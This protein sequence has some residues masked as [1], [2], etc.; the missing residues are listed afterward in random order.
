MIA[1]QLR[2]LSEFFDQIIVGAPAQT[3]AF[4]HINTLI[5]QPFDPTGET[6]GPAGTGQCAELIA[7]Q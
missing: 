2:E 3:T 1:E 6:K 4:M 5:C 7:Q